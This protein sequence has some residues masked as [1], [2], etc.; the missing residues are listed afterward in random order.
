MIFA[1][2]IVAQSIK[3]VLSNRRHEEMRAIKAKRGESEEGIQL[4]RAA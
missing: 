3:Q 4:V 1:I 2:G